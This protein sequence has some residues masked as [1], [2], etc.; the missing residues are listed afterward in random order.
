M[1]IRNPGAKRREKRGQCSGTE[2]AKCIMWPKTENGGQKQKIEAKI[3]KRGKEKKRTTW[4]NEAKDEKI[5]GPG[6]GTK[7]KKTR[8]KAVKAAERRTRFGVE[9]GIRIRIR[10]SACFFGASRIWIRIH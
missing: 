9:L 5:G 8:S 10:R 3:Q 6:S 2:A 7:S 4:Q 1:R